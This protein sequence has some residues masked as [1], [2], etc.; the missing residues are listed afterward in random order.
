MVVDGHVDRPGPQRL[1]LLRQL[2]PQR[3]R[4]VQPA[5]EPGAEAA[6]DVLDDEDGNG[7]VRGKRGQDAVEGRRSARGGGD[8]DD[9]GGHV[10]QGR[11]GTAAA[12]RRPRAGSSS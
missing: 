9:L 7:E 11:R 8:G 2:D 12:R 1:A 3:R 5:R 10:V 6:R 4:L